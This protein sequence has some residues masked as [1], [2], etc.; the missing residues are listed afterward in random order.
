MHIWIGKRSTVHEQQAAKS[1]AAKFSAAKNNIPIVEANEGSETDAFW[2]SIPDS[3]VPIDGKT[4]AYVQ[5]PDGEKNVHTHE[6]R[7]FSCLATDIVV[8]E[9]VVDF[10]QDDLYMD[11]SSHCCVLD[12]SKFVYLWIGKYASDQTKQEAIKWANSY[13]AMK[14]TDKKAVNKCVAVNQYQEPYIFTCNF[15]GW[16]TVRSR[17]STV[18]RVTHQAQ[19]KSI[20]S[21]LTPIEQLLDKYSKKIYPY[22]RLLQDPLPENVDRACMETYLSEEEF[23]EIFDMSRAEFAKLAKWKQVDAKKK[24]YLY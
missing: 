12:A 17:S 5:Y 8:I 4:R 16:S 11:N 9:E 1:A 3:N 10:A 6:P 24:L 2:Q 19:N 14:S 21:M 23:A 15:R 13:A 18:F 7:L 20:T 22:Q